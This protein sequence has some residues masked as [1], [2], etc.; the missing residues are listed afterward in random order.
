LGPA[1]GRGLVD[2]GSYVYNFSEWLEVKLKVACGLEVDDV[3]ETS[4]LICVGMWMRFDKGCFLG[5]S[6]DFRVSG[7][8]RFSGG[9]G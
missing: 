8:Y 6:R 5:L 9:L 1:A 7:A 4:W 3:G 2:L